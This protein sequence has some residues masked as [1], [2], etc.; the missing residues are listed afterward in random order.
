M[1]LHY[2]PTSP[3]VRKVNVL[4]LELGLDAQ[5]ERI[6]TNPWEPDKALLGNNPL[7]KVPTLITDDGLVLFDSPVICEYLDNEFGGNRLIPSYGQ[8]RWKALRLQALADGILDAAIL[9][10]LERKRKAKSTEWDASQRE[11]VVR[12]LDAL[13][14]EVASWGDTLTIGQIAAA[15]ALGYLDFRFAEEDWRPDRPGLTE[16]YSAFSRRHSMSTTVPRM[17]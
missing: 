8:A 17:P 7:S 1:K 2:S 9:R 15:V 10:F 16:W 4:A 14:A 3:Y 13:E 12:A 11:A 6:L 5:I